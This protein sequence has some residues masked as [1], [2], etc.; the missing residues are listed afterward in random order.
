MQSILRP[1]NRLAPWAPTLL[2]VVLGA[3]MAYHGFKKFDN[4]IEGFEAMLKGL[5][6]PLPELAAPLTAGVELVGGILLIVGLATRI[7]AAAIF[8]VLVGAVWLVTFDLGLISEIG[9]MPGMERDFSIMVGLAAVFLL[10]P[11][12]LSVDEMLG[13]EED[14]P[15]AAPVA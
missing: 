6:V 11:G 1:L 15:I 4:G 10:G 8:L 13:L 5:D 7:S 3:I 9:E 12:R 14:S 2:R